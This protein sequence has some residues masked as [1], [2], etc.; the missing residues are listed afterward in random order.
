METPPGNFL[1]YPEENRNQ[2]GSYR[3]TFTVPEGWQDRQ[4]FLAFEGVDS[5]FYL[6]I[7]GK[8][9][10][11]SQD[12]RTTAEFR[13]TDFLIEGRKHR[14]SRSLSTQRRLLSRRPGYVASLRNFS[15]RLPLV[16][17]STRPAGYRSQ[18]H[19]RERLHHQTAITQT[20]LQELRSQTPLGQNRTLFSA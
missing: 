4:T 18:R 16:R 6:W 5:A 1:T 7:N 15:R 11:Y 17:G 19:P 20:D 9:V 14:R 10:G 8:K 3:R 13:I 2:V 12:S